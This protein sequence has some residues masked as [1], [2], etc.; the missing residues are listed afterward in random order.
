MAD[1]NNLNVIFGAAIDGLLDGTSEAKEAISGVGSTVDSLNSTFNRLAAAIGLAFSIEGIKS[2]IESTAQLGSSLE[3]TGAQMGMTNEQTVELSG[4]SKIVGVDVDRLT[5]G[6]QRLYLSLQRSTR[7]GLNPAAQALRVLHLSAS[8]LI[9]LPADQF[10]EKL[11]TQIAKF[12]P[13]MNL[14]T[15]LMQLGAREFAHL[16]GPL[17]ELGKRYEEMRQKVIAASEGVAQ[18]VPGLSDSHEKITLLG[19]AVQSLGVRIFS[20]FKPAIDAVVT[21]MTKW[22]ESLKTEDIRSAVIKIGDATIEVGRQMALF[23]VDL[24]VTYDGIKDKLPFILGAMTAVAVA[25]R[26]W[27]VAAALAAPVI[28]QAV[29]GLSSGTGDAEKKINAAH[30]AI[31]RLADAARTGLNGALLTTKITLQDIADLSSKKVKGGLLDA[32]TIKENAAQALA[33]I[34]Q[35]YQ[36]AIKEAN[37]Y[38]D[39][40][41]EKIETLFKEGKISQSMETN[42]LLNELSIRSYSIS[43]YYDKEIAAAKA[44]GKQVENIEKEKTAALD[45]AKKE[46]QQLVDKEAEAEIKTW[47]D[48][49]DKITGAVNGQLQAILSGHEKT[50]AAIKKIEA[51]LVLSFI[52]GQIK[53]TAEYLVRKALELATTTSTEAGKTAAAATGAAARTAIGVAEGSTSI[54][55]V[56][57]SAIKSIFASAGQTSAAVAAEAAPAVGPAA[58]A[59]GAA[60][61]AAVLASALGL[62]A[63][64]AKSAAIGGYVV[65]SG[66]L[67]VHAGETIVPANITQPYAGPQGGG[68]SATLNLSAFNPNGLQSLIR[69][70]MPQLARELSTYTTMNPSTQ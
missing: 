21:A 22:V 56:L 12:N 18:A 13:S 55:S 25:L 65:D 63:G 5:T 38:Y 27:Q 32:S 67:N 66:L 46:S 70:M 39:M 17:S 23:F 6:L 2:F 47:T 60:A 35:F 24:G 10:F 36:K 62:A 68:T 1:D 37:D 31:N 52:Q 7:D 4:M 11:T 44:A 9:G 40:Q 50:G 34:E 8:D 15:A 19:I 33:G 53:A 54:L 69:D 42:E 59:V 43:L 28:I 48:A 16:V 64:S 29:N 49:A 26:Q 58:P 20:T 14:S 45:A 51:D 3:T 41:K 30:D 61:G 57:A